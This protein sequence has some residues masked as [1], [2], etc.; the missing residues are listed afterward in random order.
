MNIIWHDYLKEKP[1]KGRAF[2][3]VSKNQWG[4]I[5]IRFNYSYPLDYYGDID[6]K[7]WIYR[8]EL[9]QTLPKDGE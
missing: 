3:W 2:L 7:W 1:D 9:E 8:D 5:D 6:V 4:T